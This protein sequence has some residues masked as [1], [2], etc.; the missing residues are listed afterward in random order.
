MFRA[1]SHTY[2]KCI[3]HRRTMMHN[4]D[5]MIVKNWSHALGSLFRCKLMKP[6][7]PL[8]VEM[9]QKIQQLES[10]FIQFLSC[11]ACI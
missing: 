5:Y 8:R 3:V 1:H 7:G 10:K 11:V 9:V 6:A 2:D 4:D